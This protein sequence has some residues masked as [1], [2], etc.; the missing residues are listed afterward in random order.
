MKTIT[1][2][3]AKEIDFNRASVALGTFDGLHRGHNALIQA[4]LNHK[5]DTVAFTFDTLPINVFKKQ[6]RPMQ[7]FTM[8][9]KIEAF[10]KTGI[11]Y[12]CVAHFDKDFAGLTRDE[13]ETLI[14]ETFNPDNI[15]AGYNYTF[16]KNAEGTAEVLLQ[17]VEKLGCNVEVIPK[18]L[19]NGNDVSSTKIRESLWDGNIRNANELLGYQYFISEVVLKCLN[20]NSKDTTVVIDIPQKKIAPKNGSYSVMTKVRGSFYD[21]VCKVGEFAIGN[22][23]TIEVVIQDLN[24]DI[25]NEPVTVVF[26][27][28]LRD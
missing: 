17:D 2:K 22:K 1:L 26:K 15:I 6:H 23:R 11:D 21:A 12:L 13:F 14:I 8:Q 16:G 20:R 7:L 3:K 19:V 4:A 24:K 27:E 9:E 28:R 18:V 5:G 25:T 10:S